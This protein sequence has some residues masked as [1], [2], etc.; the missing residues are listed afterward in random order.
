MVCGGAISGRFDGLL[1]QTVVGGFQHRKQRGGLHGNRTTQLSLQKR[2]CCVTTH[3]VEKTMSL[4]TLLGGVTD[5]V[6]STTAAV[7]VAGAGAGRGRLQIRWHVGHQ[8]SE[9]R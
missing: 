7:A 5:F 6:V 3:V 8:R 9:Q 1:Q 4:E 2:G